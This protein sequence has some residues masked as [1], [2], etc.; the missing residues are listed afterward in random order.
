MS[1]AHEA[2]KK[3]TA[4][5]DKA[6]WGRAKLMVVGQGR[7]GKTSTVRRLLGRG[8]NANEA[9]T[10]GLQ[11]KQEFSVD[12]T[13]TVNGFVEVDPEED[14][15]RRQVTKLARL[16]Y[17]NGG[18][19]KDSERAAASKP[20]LLAI[21][22]EIFEEES[23]KGSTP[24]A[25]KV[26][27]VEPRQ[28]ERE[29]GG[30]TKEEAEEEEEE[31]AQEEEQA[32]ARRVS[33]EE[34]DVARRYSESIFGTI[35]DGEEETKV[36]LTIW[37]YGGQRVFYA[38]HHLFL[39]EY[40]VYTLVFD[41]REVLNKEDDAVE[42]L[43]FW[44][45]SI[46]LHAP[47]APIVL[48]GTYRDEVDDTKRWKDIDTVLRNR[49]KVV[50]AYT[51]QLVPNNADGLSFFPVDNCNDKGLTD[52]R[53]AILVALTGKEFMEYP[54]P[55]SW[56]SCLGQLLRSETSS[57]GYMSL[58]EVE[59]IARKHRVKETS[60]VRLMLSFFHEIGVL[61]YFH[62]SKKL[63]HIVILDTQWLVDAMT[64]LI[65]DNDI[66]TSNIYDIRKSLRVDEETFLN[67]GVLSQR[68]R[69]SKWQ[70]GEYSLDVQQKLLSLME[71]MLLVC[72]WPWHERQGAFLVPSVL[73][74]ER[75]L[76]AP[77][78]TRQ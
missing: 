63:R 41:M 29:K 61:F 73:L 49:V 13:R 8:F 6:P 64:C 37:D 62:R 3:A 43:Q 77:E 54:V 15:V 33:E 1:R 68:L 39:T 34:F 25:E 60:E 46:A 66:H 36:Q 28:P 65:F 7:A 69:K 11:T 27:G 51:G 71:D 55:L 59:V 21:H 53:E 74:S 56:I 45:K 58:L 2:L 57:V 76:N 10:L 19:A 52:V 78:E 67:T 22:E 26:K 75:S 38:L 9:S 18:N 16:R 70:K 4:V 50:A 14:F 20:K 17:Q 48:V 30:E 44:L 23:L 31:E 32:L 24:G 47:S 35:I 5:G 12:L 42:Y 40:G 72:K